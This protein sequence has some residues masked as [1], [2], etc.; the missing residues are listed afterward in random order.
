MM[1]NRGVMIYRKLIQEILQEQIDNL[2]NL[3]AEE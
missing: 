1:S 2:I 3:K